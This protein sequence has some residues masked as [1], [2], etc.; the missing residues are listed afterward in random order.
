MQSFHRALVMTSALFMAA[1]IFSGAGTGPG[2]ALGRPMLAQ[3]EPGQ[4]EIEDEI[5]KSRDVWVALWNSRKIYQ[6][7]TFYA[8]DAMFL[9]ASGERANGLFEIRY[10]FERMRNSNTSDLKLHSL[11]FEQSGD[12]AYDSG[13]YTETMALPDNP[14]HEI[15]GSYL[16]VY[17]HQPDGR[18]LIVQHVWTAASTPHVEIKPLAGP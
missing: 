1:P 8:P 3:E 15:R 17:K 13:S 6:V 12:L 16:A 18:W 7:L 2:P 10:L 5:A 4:A 14:H 9:T 11:A